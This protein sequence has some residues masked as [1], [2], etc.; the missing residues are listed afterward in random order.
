[1][2]AK[3]QDTDAYPVVGKAGQ[4][5]PQLHVKKVT[6]CAVQRVSINLSVMDPYMYT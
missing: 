4:K 3:L 6:K 2:L 5:L 1:M